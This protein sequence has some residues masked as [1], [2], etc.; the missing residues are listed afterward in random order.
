MQLH[1]SSTTGQCPVRLMVGA[2]DRQQQ[3][4]LAL[5]FRALEASLA[6]GW[7]VAAERFQARRMAVE[8]TGRQ[9]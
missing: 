1:P 9:R 4:W 8:C 2:D 6:A 7:T 5:L 3:G